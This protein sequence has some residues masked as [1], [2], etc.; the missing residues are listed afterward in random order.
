MI[1]NIEN[2]IPLKECK[3]GYLYKIAARNAS[4]GI[5][6]QK[7]NSFII[8]RYKFKDNYLFPEYH[9]DTGEPYGTVKPLEEMNKAPEEMT[10]EEKLNYLNSIGE[11]NDNTINR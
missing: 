7:D 9:W 11:N 1:Y 6:N 2:W 10:D 3:D 5:F 8:S 4:Y